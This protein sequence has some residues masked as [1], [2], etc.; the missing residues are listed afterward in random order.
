MFANTY[1]A[2]CVFPVCPPVS[3]LISFF[4]CV[5]HK[6]DKRLHQVDTNVED[7]DALL[8][9]HLKGYH[10]DFCGL[11]H[12]GTGKRLLLCPGCDRYLCFDSGVWH[13]AFTLGLRD[14]KRPNGFC[15]NLAW[16][17]GPNCMVSERVSE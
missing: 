3:F 1:H 17:H 8:V 9:R 7:W 16:A 13:K 10:C 12:V 11:P 14:H 15:A 6:C 5:Q 2:C 4:A